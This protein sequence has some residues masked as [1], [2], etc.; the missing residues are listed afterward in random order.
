MECIDEVLELFGCDDPFDRRYCFRDS[1]ID[2]H[3]PI[4][5]KVVRFHIAK[6]I[7]RVNDEPQAIDL[8]SATILLAVKELSVVGNLAQQ[9]LLPDELAR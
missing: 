3:G 6:D 8:P 5:W 9:P 1:L 2:R 4:V 7:A